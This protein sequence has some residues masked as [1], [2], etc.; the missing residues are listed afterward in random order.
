MDRKTGVTFNR[1]KLLLCDQAV[2]VYCDEIFSPVEIK[3]WVDLN[4]S[5]IGQT[6]LCPHCEVD[7]VIGFSGELDRDWVVQFRKHHFA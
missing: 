1:K 7:S 5:N 6:A 3:N 2:C 4:S